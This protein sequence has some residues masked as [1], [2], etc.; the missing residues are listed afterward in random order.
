MNMKRNLIVLLACLAT[1]IALGE[2]S[3][4][5]KNAA[6]NAAI[7]KDWESWN[8]PFQ[9][10]RLLG[11]I[12][13][14]GAPASVRFSSPRRKA[15]SSWIPGLKRPCREFARAYRN[16]PYPSNAGLV[17]P[18]LRNRVRDESRSAGFQA[19][20]VASFQTCAAWKFSCAS[21][22][23]RSAD[24][25]VGDT[26]GW[27]TCATYRTPPCFGVRVKPERCRRTGPGETQAQ[28]PQRIAKG[29]GSRTTH[30]SEIVS[31]TRILCASLR[32][33]RLFRPKSTP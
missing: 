22:V 10:F 28:R 25:E 2:P 11:N 7:K 33:L 5:E 17:N 24:S 14:V 4:A 32:S 19:C 29:N 6:E 23:R 16:S 13:Y 9:P 18:E 1:Q 27:E 26:A 8:A 20:G 3:L 12:H 31:Q 15:T 21:V 30:H